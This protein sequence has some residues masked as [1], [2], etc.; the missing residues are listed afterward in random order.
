MRLTGELTDCLQKCAALLRPGQPTA[1]LRRQA[2]HTLAWASAAGVTQALDILHTLA[3]E[4]VAAEAVVAAA[5]QRRAATRRR[6]SAAAHRC[7]RAKQE[8]GGERGSWG[9]AGQG[10]DGAKGCS[11]DPEGT[12]RG[13]EHPAGAGIWEAAD[14]AAGMAAG[15][16]AGSEVE[17][18]PAPEQVEQQE[19][20]E[21]DG[22]AGESV[23]PF[24]AS[25]HSRSWSDPRSQ[26]TGGAIARRGKMELAVPRASA[27]SA[28]GG[29]Q[30]LSASQRA[31]ARAADEAEAEAVRESARTAVTGADDVLGGRPRSLGQNGAF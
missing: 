22:H 18:Q 28:R 9:A 11:Q 16:A 17:P 27:S 23:Q 26:L 6:R 13:E 12:L 14:A 15:I 19:D 20:E 21:E 29:G 1:R 30:P 8:S 10:P 4:D 2:T 7:L 24:P 3:E 5:V 31:W 25:L